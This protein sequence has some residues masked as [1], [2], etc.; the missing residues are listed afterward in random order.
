M[1]KCNFNKVAIQI[2]L[3]HG[4]SPVNLLNIFRTLF[5]RNTYSYALRALMFHIPHA[6]HALLL[7]TM[8]CKPLLME[9]HYSAFFH[10][11]YKPP[12]SINLRLPFNDQCSHHIETSQLICRANQLTGFYIK[13]TF[14][15][16]RLTSLHY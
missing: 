9:C 3:W 2:I 16:K 11:W 15:V 8:I 13:G 10:K 14:I 1:P 4:Y 12:R 6:I 5:P 7:T